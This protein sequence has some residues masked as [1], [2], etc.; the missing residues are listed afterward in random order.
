MYIRM[1]IVSCSCIVRNG[2]L[3]PK[4]CVEDTHIFST[5]WYYHLLVVDVY[6]TEPRM[7]HEDLEI[8]RNEVFV[9]FESQEKG[10]RFL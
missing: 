7:D 5:L 1:Y 9:T 10:N 6:Y 8:L 4:L 3:V 2:S